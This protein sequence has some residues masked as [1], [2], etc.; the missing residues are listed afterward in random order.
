MDAVY[1]KVPQN[2]YPCKIYIDFSGQMVA[3][4]SQGI[5][6]FYNSKSVDATWFEIYSG[7][8]AIGFGEESAETAAGTIYT[9]KLEIRFP[10]NDSLR[11]VRLDYLRK[12]KFI[13]IKLTDK[14]YLVLGRND[15]LQNKKP[16]ISTESNEKLTAVTFGNRS[17]FP[18]AFLDSEIS[19]TI[20]NLNNSNLTGLINGINTIFLTATEF[21][22]GSTKLYRNG[23]RQ[24]LGIDYTESTTVGVVFTIA[25]LTGDIL[26]IDYQTGNIV[27]NVTLIGVRN[28]INVNFTTPSPFA[29]GQTNVFRNG[30]LLQLG[31]DYYESGS[32]TIVFVVPPVDTDLLVIDYQMN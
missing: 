23:V 17:L 14:R 4:N 2:P 26:V 3:S 15:Y 29:I 8:A 20:V 5:A 25:P 28:G 9:Q 32:S 27:S 1:K 31:I 18:A 22:P 13:A 12:A 19:G 24:K 30:V 21:L 6:S 16:S 11:A 10:S 7:K